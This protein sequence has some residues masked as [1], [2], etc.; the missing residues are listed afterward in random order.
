VNKAEISRSNP[1]PDPIRIQG[2]DDKKRKKNVFSLFFDQKCGLLMTNLQEQPSAFKK[3]HPALQKIN[4][5]TYSMFVG[6]F[7]PPGSGSK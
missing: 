1:D 6:Y 3:E 5:L 7:C 4:L 2:F